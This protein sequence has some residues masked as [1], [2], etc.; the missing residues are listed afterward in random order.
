MK[1]GNSSNY[2]R[3]NYNVGIYCR[4]SS[5]DG[6]VGESNSIGNQKRMLTKYVMEKGW[7]I[8]DIYIDDGYSGTNFDRPG[9]KRLLEDIKEKKISSVITKDMS[10]LGR[11]YIQVGYYIEKFFPENR[12]RYIAVNDNVD[13]VKDRGN[14]DVTPFKA[15]INDM[16]CKDISKKVRSVL[17][18]K[19][20]EGKFIGAF[21]PFGYKKNP[22][23]K[24]H[25]ILD[26]EA[27]PIV[28]RIF[29]M[30]LEEV[31]FTAIARVLN[32][33]GIPTPAYYK[34]RKY[35]TY[36]MG[37]MRVA[38]WCH[39]S[40]KAI[41]KNPVYTG[42]VAQNKYR[43]INYKSKKLETLDKDEWIVVK[44]THEEIISQQEF[45]QAQRLMNQK[46]DNF[47]GAKR[48]VK[49]FSGFVFC[50]DCGEYMTYIKTRSK[51]NY[52]IC[53][54]YKRFGKK[55]CSRHAILQEKLEEMIL[56]DFR[57]LVD[58]F[59]DKEKLKKKAG[60]IID[61]EKDPTKSYENELHMVQKR[62]EEMKLLLKSLY[63]DKVK[64][65]IDESQ[66]IELY[67]D[68]NKEKKNLLRR[69]D[70]LLNMLKPKEPTD[71]N[72]RV[73]KLM[74]SVLNLK[75]LNRIILTELI[76]KIE[77][78]QGEDIKIYYKI[79]NL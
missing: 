17:N 67:N 66:L 64:G 33:E 61:S 29:Q 2:Q 7:N 44:G 11:D 52:L 16:Y 41:L 51:N 60:K 6:E 45:D 54:G 8:V 39:G 9:F 78:F 55:H 72:E 24:S 74:N 63:E 46:R 28:K 49:L 48:N 65:M 62:L 71:K 19:R 73:E 79:K 37:K 58:R 27:A 56:S 1:N 5:D 47:S 68:F 18:M 42:S 31:G 70:E 15:I 12:I 34:K 43:K 53:S 13:T 36:N 30:Y 69:Q 23:D 32:E 3:K 25:L 57:K 4:L 77:I 38:K 76:D 26:E 50:G 22:M 14:N 10:R 75:S 40:V 21:A 35:D 59:A 20:E